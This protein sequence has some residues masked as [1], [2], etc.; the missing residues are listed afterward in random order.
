MTAVSTARSRVLAAALELFAEFGVAGT[1]LQM[2]A[3][4]LGVAKAAVYHQFHTKDEIAMAAVRPGIDAL[5]EVVDQA[6]TLRTAE[7]R[8]DAALTGLVRASVR[9]RDVTAIFQ[10]DA[11][12]LR[13]IQ[14]DPR[15][16]ALPVRLRAV[17]GGPRPDRSQRVAV[18]MTIAAVLNVA[19]DADLADLDDETIVAEVLAVARRM[20]PAPAAGR[21]RG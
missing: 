12:V 6:E 7:G 1:S 19:Y 14:D 4:R 13:L 5:L 16:S 20:V 3:D 18:D 15:I 8:Q 10:R 11:V 2:I 17:L 9:H 21:R